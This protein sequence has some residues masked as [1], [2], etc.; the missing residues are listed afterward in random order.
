MGYRC[1]MVLQLAQSHYGDDTILEKIVGD[2]FDPPLSVTK[3]G[4]VYQISVPEILQP[5]AER[6]HMRG[7][8]L[9]MLALLDSHDIDYA[10]EYERRGA[11]RTPLPQLP[12]EIDMSSEALR[13][14]TAQ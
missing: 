12:P 6:V 11:A 3:Q 2:A 1:L 10:F 14:S 5:S 13:D 4:A 7:Y 8:S 9:Q